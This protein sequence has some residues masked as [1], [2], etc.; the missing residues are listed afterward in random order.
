MKHFKKNV[1]KYVFDLAIVTFGVFLAIF[2]NG[3]IVQNKI[4][5]DVKKSINYIIDELKLNRDQLVMIIE[6]H[7]KIK[8]N[9]REVKSRV[10][11]K[12]IME[13]Y[14]SSKAFRFTHIKDW[15]GISLPNY[16]NIAFEGAKI[17]GITQEFDIETIQYIS[18]AYKLIE[19]NAEF[20]KTVLN[21]MLAID[22]NT[23]V[24]DAMGMISLL[25]SD[26]LNSEISL[27]AQLDHT[28]EN[29]Q[30]LAEESGK[31]KRVN[32]N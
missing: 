12:E 7:Q 22:S 26:V 28:I 17:S 15:V 30:N 13:P 27:K 20:G 32:P 14:F 16:E 24:A 11:D 4:D 9:F 23:K 8:E 31:M 6:Y 29:I 1:L 2:V 25:T 19:F 18:Q 5:R 21:K 3:K 10:S